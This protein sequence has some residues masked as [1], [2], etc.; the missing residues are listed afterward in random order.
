MTKAYYYLPQTTDEALEL[1]KK[2]NGSAAIVCGGTDLIVQMKSGTKQFDV[3]VDIS[4]IPALNTMQEEEDTIVIGGAV[5]H[6]RVA[7]A[8]FIQ[9]YATALAQGCG[10]VGSPQIRNVGSLSGNIV[11]AQPA[12]DSAIALIALEAEA[13]ICGSASQRTCKVEALYQDV[14]KSR[15]DYCGEIITALRFA[16]LDPARG[17]ASAVQRLSQRN[18][19]SLPMLNVAVA[20]KISAKETIDWV[21]ISI[22]PVA[23]T[24]FRS[25]A[26]EKIFEGAPATEAVFREIGDYY[27]LLAN[28]RS[29]RLRGGADYRK[30]MVSVLTERALRDAAAT[31]RG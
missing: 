24:P 16:K 17:E 21:R 19:L 29:S 18:M 25:P 26:A 31:V 28:P 20:L 12:A 13:T 23:R 7:N 2:H 4:R 27:R 9:K 30:E 1:L 14:G 6:A 11:N 5:T 10:I 15:V 22:G 3:L 8:P